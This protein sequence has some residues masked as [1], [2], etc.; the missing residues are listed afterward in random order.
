M[1]IIRRMADW[2]CNTVFNSSTSTDLL[3]V[4]FFVD[5]RD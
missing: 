1:I 5:F 4:S 2:I 3:R